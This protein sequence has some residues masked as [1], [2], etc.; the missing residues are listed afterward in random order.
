MR[1]LFVSDKAMYE[2]TVEFQLNRAVDN[3]KLAQQVHKRELDKKDEIIQSLQKKVEDLQYQSRDFSEMK[4]RNEQENRELLYSNQIMRQQL[5]Q[6][7]IKNEHI[8]EDFNRLT[9]NINFYEEKI[10]HLE[11]EHE[12]ANHIIKNLLKKFTKNAP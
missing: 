3:I 1:P 6:E 8:R 12:K 11:S 9:Q 7:R 10:A 5:S 2:T 4:R